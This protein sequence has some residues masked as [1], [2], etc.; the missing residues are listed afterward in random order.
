MEVRL[1][2]VDTLY[3]AQGC[4]F[5]LSLQNW[6]ANSLGLYRKNTN[7]RSCGFRCEATTIQGFRYSALICIFAISGRWSKLISLNKELW[8][9]FR[10]PQ[11]HS[12]PQASSY[13][14][15]LSRFLRFT[16]IS[17]VRRYWK[18]FYSTLTYLCF[19]LSM[20]WHFDRCK[21]RHRPGCS[22]TVQSHVAGRPKR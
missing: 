21:V 16:I 10:R 11:P 7:D 2:T 9:M 22:C 19:D 4:S 14:R 12:M 8:G 20:P 15:N 6:N 17:V 3:L 13:G 1:T 5:S 18:M